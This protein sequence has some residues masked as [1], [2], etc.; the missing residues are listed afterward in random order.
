MPAAGAAEGPAGALERIELVGHGEGPGVGMGQ[1]GAFGYAVRYHYPYKRILAHFYGGTRTTT[2]GAL[3]MAFE[4]VLKVAI[5]ENVNL[6]TNVGYDPVVTSAAGFRVEGQSGPL[7]PGTSGASTSGTSGASTSGTSGASTSG[8]SGS[9]GAKGVLAVAA[10]D[11]VDLHLEA[12]GTWAVFEGSS[13]AAAKTAARRGRAPVAKGLIDPVVRPASNALLAPV[14]Q[15]LTLCRHDGVDETL[16]GAIEAYD[17]QGFERTL[18]LVP[19][20]AYLDG[21][22][23]AEVAA[24]WGTDGSNLGAPQGRPWGFQALEAQ[25]VAAR[26]YAL[27]MAE[28]GGW[29]GYASICDSIFCQ[30]YVG[31]DYEQAVSNAAVKATAGQVQVSGP[32][33]GTIV[34]AR[35][36]ASSG[37]WTAPSS[38]P[39]VADLGDACVVPGN[40]LECNPV[41]T[42][43]ATLSASALAHA[44]P[45]L[46]QLVSIRVLARDHR[47]S[48]GGR[49]LSVEL[50][51]K[52][53]REIVPAASFAGVLGLNS[54]WFAISHALRG[55][56][57][58]PK[59]SLPPAGEPPATVPTTTMPPTSTPST[60]VPPMSAPSTT[61]PSAQTGAA[62]EPTAAL[63]RASRSPPARSLAA[64]S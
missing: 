8:T 44:F 63:R 42:W 64:L 38:F 11:A 28:A 47:G 25:A 9:Q 59:K 18:N 15:L 54:D 37:G 13:C 5:L 23:P 12:N 14:G 3:G 7:G 4:P 45:R 10:G 24:S 53:E 55:E 22:V 39:A 19:L 48:L 1:W 20:D 46:G 2:L 56:P 6:S 29:R 31:V 57:S 27:A 50:V 33:P 34:L 36:A 43:Q 58:A 61:A 26:T 17:R 32:A 30:A 21:V 52:D 51:G 35:Y 40:P 41:H 62:G 49:A 60:L 16:R